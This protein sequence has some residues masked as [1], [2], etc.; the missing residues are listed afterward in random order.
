MEPARPAPLVRFG[1]ETCGDPAAASR[2]EW[3]ITN[4]L[5]GY[6]SVALDGTPVR[7]YSGWLIAALEPPV[8][9][10][11]LV[12]AILERAT[13]AGVTC[14]L[15]VLER[16]GRGRDPDGGRYLEHFELEGTRPV[17]RYAVGG[18]LLERTAWMGHGR[19]TTYVRYRV[20]RGGPV[21]LEVTPLV[22]HRDHHE[23]PP[24]DRR[25]IT[26]TVAADGL[27]VGWP[28]VATRLQLRGAGGRV[29]RQPDGNGAGWVR[30]ISHSAETERGL[31]D[32]SDLAAPGHFAVELADSA[33]WTLV[34]S[35]EAPADVDL[36]AEAALAGARAREAALLE[37]A[38]SAGA[39]IVDP[40]VRQLVLAADQFIVARAIPGEAGVG[41][42]VIAG[43]PWF[44]DWGRDT[45][46]ALPGL[47]DAS[48]ILRG[49]APWVRDGLLPNSFPDA[50]RVEPAY[51]TA[52]AALWYAHAVNAYRA[53]TG[54]EALVDDLLPVLRGILDHYLAGTRFGIGVDPDDGLLY[55][56]EP[57]VQLTWM[58]A[59]A[60]EWVVTPRV[61][62]PVEIQALWIHACRIVSGF[63][64][65]RG[66]PA[67]AERYASLGERAATSFRA[68]Y[69][70]PDRGCLFDV[71]D[72]PSGDDPALRLNQILA[73]SLEPDLVAPDHARAVMAAVTGT[74]WIGLGL[75]TLAPSDPDYLGTYRGKP[76]AAR[77]R[78]SPGDRL[79]LAR[80]RLRGGAAS[81]WVERRRGSCAPRRILGSSPGRR[82][83]HGVGVPGRR[84]A[85]STGR[86][87]RPG[88]GRRRGASGASPRD[89]GPRV[90]PAVSRRRAPPPG[91]RRHRC[92]P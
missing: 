56:G 91:D 84:P 70:N 62:K 86:L 53:S 8:A 25:P 2:R 85:P 92:A 46:I 3:L 29:V 83:W 32:V 41:R 48:A 1:R 30:G 18:A 89:V 50:E 23:L 19:N 75:R 58:D 69:W 24:T 35:A 42:S 5:G 16:P 67:S 60:G 71:V 80:W 49:F 52:D 13:A 76:G 38:H 44:N 68:R 7:R 45:M 47:D 39:D 4:G 9:R 54:D 64:L 37:Q 12:G 79:D 36:D 81:R 22:T 90:S 87:L 40:L 77:R 31:D 51:H 34:M 57:G 82:S 88:V 59:K 15:G 28:G 26:T 55:A 63:C 73:L 43:Y 65:D 11:V 10:T 20:L 17:W 61:G 72:G 6:A 33:A 66:D 74:L 27:E 21:A 78:V 14:E